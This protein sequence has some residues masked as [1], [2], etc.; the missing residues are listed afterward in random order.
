MSTV[1]ISIFHGDMT[2]MRSTVTS[3]TFMAVGAFSLILASSASTVFY[4][5]R[6]EKAGY[7]ETALI[8]FIIPF[9]IMDIFFIAQ[10]IWLLSPEVIG[11][12]LVGLLAPAFYAIPLAIV[13]IFWKYLLDK[14]KSRHQK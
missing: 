1:L 14:I 11:P 5:K 10:T 12:F 7:K 9:I 6:N 13:G 2:V 4:L 8:S 3:L